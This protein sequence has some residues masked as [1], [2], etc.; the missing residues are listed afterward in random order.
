M[1]LEVLAPRHQLLVVGR[2]LEEAAPLRVGET[3]DHGVRQGPGL[4][5]P[6]GLERGLV[7]RQ[8]RFEQERVVLQ[9]GVQLGLSV[10]VGAQQAPLPVAQLAQ[11]EV[12]RIA[13]RVQEAR[14]F[15][16]RA[17]LG[18]GGDGQRV[19]GGQALV[20]QPGPDALS[21][22]LV[23]PA[24]DAGQVRG[25]L[26][27]AGEDGPALEVAA[28]PDAEVCGRRL[29]V[30]GPQHLTELVGRPHV[31]QALL[32]LGVGVQGRHEAPLGPAQLGEHPVQR[33][34]AD[35]A[36]Q[37]V[38]RDLPPVQVG[39]RQQRVVVEHLLEVRDHPPRVHRVAREPAPDLVVHAAAGHGPERVQAHLQDAFAGQGIRALSRAAAREQELDRRGGRELGRAPEAAVLGVVDPA[40]PLD[41]GVQHRS[42]QRLGGGLEAGAAAQALGHLLGRGPDLVGALVPRLAHGVQNGR[43]GGH[44]LPVLGREVG[45]GVVGHLLGGQEHVQRPAALS[46]HGLAR[47][48][49]DGVQVGPL[50]AVELDAHEALVH[51][52]RG[53][54]VLERLALHH[55]APVAR[56]VAD[57]QQDRDVALARRGQRLGPPRVPVHGVVLVLEQVGRGLARQ[58]VGHASEARAA[59]RGRCGAE[60]RR[61]PAG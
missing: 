19:P 46:G 20:V 49:V 12:R 32:A 33:L 45:A 61:C 18:Q 60:R 42:V 39:P 10:L 59:E 22:G 27:A 17:G 8:Q 28:R 52:R 57:R 55:V 51:E 43:P 4:G 41:R 47:L 7:E 24:A 1:V 53:V 50:L 44:P 56:R 34:R 29:G 14:L 30:V 26:V 3:L 9:V 36:Q 23:E 16:G 54:L 13:G 15:Q 58:T 6:A 35:P 2:G 38:A 11:D 21:P 5:E 48:H 25:L 31:E 37:I 40:Q